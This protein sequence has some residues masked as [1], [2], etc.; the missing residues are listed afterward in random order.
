MHPVASCNGRLCAAHP[1]QHPANL[2]R[3]RVLG[4][5]AALGLGSAAQAQ[6]DS[7][8]PPQSIGRSAPPSGPG[9]A[10]ADPLAN[11]SAAD[12]RAAATEAV[13]ALDSLAAAADRIVAEIPGLQSSQA[14]VERKVREL[15][16]QRDA[17][18]AEY[19]DGLFCSGCGQTRSQILAKGE[20]F[21]HPGETIVRPTGQQIASKERALQSPIDQQRSLLNSLSQRLDTLRKERDEAI[22]QIQWGVNYWETGFSFH[23]QV[24]S[25]RLQHAQ[26]QNQA[27]QAEIKQV[28]TTLGQDLF[29][30]QQRAL[31]DRAPALKEQ[32]AKLQADQTHW[33]K[34]LAQ[35]DKDHAQREKKLQAALREARERI[36]QDASTINTALQRPN[37]ARELTLVVSG[38]E[39]NPFA[40][41]DNLGVKF[42]LGDYT[43]SRRAD[44]LPGVQRMVDRYRA[45]D[46]L[47]IASGTQ[48]VPTTGTAPAR[49][50]PTGLLNPPPPAD[51]AGA[52]KVPSHLI[53]LP[54]P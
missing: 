3:R 52:K 5:F 38:S 7:L 22:D 34:S 53:D 15:E 44:V 4:L 29:Q 32:I 40:S 33:N 30:A 50:V 45:L 36:P 42:R 14:E 24:L 9:A 27:K 51:K 49:T 43:P 35:L 39:K 8:L 12:G 21:P 11:I 23:T 10:G 26:A 17:L 16:S 1:T 31:L 37:L 19:R 54:P 41:P 48:A 47:A 2:H 46:S 28:L 18:M 25:M 13:H 20:P 6:S